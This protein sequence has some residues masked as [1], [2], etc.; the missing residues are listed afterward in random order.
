[1][2]SWHRVLGAGGQQARERVSMAAE[3]LLALASTAG[4]TVVQ[5]ATTDAWQAAK[6][7]IARVLGR[8]D[9]GR[10]RL[11]EGR[12]EEAHVKLTASA[13]VIRYRAGRACVSLLRDELDDIEMHGVD[14][15]HSV[16]RVPPFLA[17][18]ICSCVWKDA[19]EC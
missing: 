7:G 18:E 12:L 19:P 5:S 11:A 14:S 9:A 2:G 4:Q 17:R 1:M 15:F 10:T 6:K 3:G 16:V 13:G 8:G